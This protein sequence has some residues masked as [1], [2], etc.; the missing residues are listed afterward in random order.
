MAKPL[1]DI[2]EHEIFLKEKSPCFYYDLAC[3]CHYLHEIIRFPVPE[4]LKEFD[5]RLSSYAKQVERARPSAFPNGD[6]IYI[7]DYRLNVLFATLD[8]D[9]QMTDFFLTY[10]GHGHDGQDA[11]CDSR[12]W[13]GQPYGAPYPKYEMVNF[14][15]E[16]DFLP[17]EELFHAVTVIFCGEE[18]QEVIPLSQFQTALLMEKYRDK[19]L[20]DWEKIIQKAQHL[21]VY[22]PEQP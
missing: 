15:L 9:G 11:Y 18:L 10:S 22:G 17:V 7:I 20:L 4:L 3:Y 19:S 6:R 2:F 14:L 13:T 21:C 12:P 1:C 16:Y 8:P 5:A